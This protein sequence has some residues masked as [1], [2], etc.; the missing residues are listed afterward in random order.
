M[1]AF[2]SLRTVVGCGGGRGGGM[3]GVKKFWDRGVPFA[4]VGGGGVGQDAI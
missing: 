2:K 1:R 4:W 3:E